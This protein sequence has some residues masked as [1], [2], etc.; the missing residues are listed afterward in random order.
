MQ[1]SI[2]TRT[3]NLRF[4]EKIVQERGPLFTREEILPL[5]QRLDISR[6]RLSKIIST[7]K[8]S[9]DIEILK[10]GVYLAKS[11]LF[12]GEVHPFAIAVVLVQPSAISHWSALAHHGFTTQLPTMIQASTPRQVVTP[13]MRRGQARRPR[14]R[15]VWRVSEIE[16]EYIHV[17]PQRFFGHQHIW[18]DR[19]HR[20]AITDAERTALDVIARSD[21]FGGIRAAIEIMENAL[22][23]L[24]IQRLVKYTL[25]YNEG[26]T[27]K[28]MGWI[29]E[30]LGV[31]KETLAPLQAYP[32]TT[33]YRLDPQSP[34][35]GKPNSTWQI[36]ENL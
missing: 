7:L 5:A 21:I 24:Q 29:L 10:R 1:S 25:Q 16:I 26:A 36:K 31:S 8:A 13:E 9:G 4:L 28:R 35:K 15:A 19:W 12:A 34:L 32:V 3:S 17:A 6:Q 22:P 20:V 23:S 11:P 14:G 30:H 2:R 27:I 18:V 33:Y